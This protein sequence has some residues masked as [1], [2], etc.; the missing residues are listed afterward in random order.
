MINL[1]EFGVFFN[2]KNHI[3][4]TSPFYED[5]SVLAAVLLIEILSFLVIC[6]AF[7]GD[8]SWFKRDW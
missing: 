4:Q 5:F 7:F 1:D 6:T 3:F 2:K 8:V